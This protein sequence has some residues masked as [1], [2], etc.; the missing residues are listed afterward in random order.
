MLSRDRQNLRSSCNQS[1]QQLLQLHRARAKLGHR[2]AQLV[3]DLSCV[4]PIVQISAKDDFSVS[5]AWVPDAQTHQNLSNLQTPTF[6][7]NIIIPS[8]QSS[9]KSSPSSKK[10]ISLTSGSGARSDDASYSKMPNNFD[11][12]SKIIDATENINDNRSI[13][14]DKDTQQQTRMDGS[15]PHPAIDKNMKPS[16]SPSKQPPNPPSSGS[17]YHSRSSAGLPC[18]HVP[19]H[20]SHLHGAGGSSS[21]V[22]AGGSGAGFLAPNNFLGSSVPALPHSTESLSA[23]LGMATHLLCL[24]SGLLQVRDDNYDN[25]L[26]FSDGNTF[27]M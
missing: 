11:T 22:A 1:E 25:E 14:G 12:N 17:P 24:V 18:I 7:Q 13:S 5:N 4:Y 6:Q 2:R 26:I 15:L 9:N 10:M 3:R 23:G 27:K 16:S 20:P 21:A 19:F 8:S